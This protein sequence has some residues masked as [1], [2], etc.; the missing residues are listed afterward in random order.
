MKDILSFH[1]AA[2]APVA[3]TPVA[4]ITA[5]GNDLEGSDKK[6]LAFSAGRKAS[7]LERLLS[8]FLRPTL[9]IFGKSVSAYNAFG[10]LG[11]VVAATIAFG[12]TYAKG[13]SLYVTAGLLGLALLV[14]IAN[15]VLTTLITGRDSLV[16]LRYFLT[17][18]AAA[19][20]LLRIIE[21]PILPY[22][23]NLM[24][25]IGAMQGV[26]RIGCFRVGC[27]YGKPAPFGIRYTDRYAKAGFPD[28]LIGVRLFP[29][30]LLESSWIFLSVSTGII[31]SL[32]STVT[33][34]GLSSYILIFSSGRFC[35]EL[36]RGDKA[37]PYLGWLSEAQWISVGMVCSVLILEQMQVLPFH[38]WHVVAGAVM[39]FMAAYVVYNSLHSSVFQLK[40]PAHIASISKALALLEKGR[41]QQTAGAHAV[42]LR[43]TTAGIQISD[44][45]ME[46]QNQ[47][48]HHYTLSHKGDTLALNEAIALAKIIQ[49][50]HPQEEKTKLI[51]DNR[52]TFHFLRYQ[53]I[54]S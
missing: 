23:E 18:M 34:Y 3:H 48:I 53:T 9:R 36:F 39:L 29:I 24:L 41:Q 45:I 2:H 22:L 10:V 37:R 40:K 47:R 30:Q 1:A 21:Q 44:G 35:F 51:D 4:N 8:R 14:S 12:L 15:I 28:P 11:M 20:L 19:A 50:W 32:T 52:N 43:Q 7:V 6:V 17:I 26:G 33:G 54:E 49:S 27:C 25:G 13:L 38:L 31:L 42:H 46:I 16:F 5:Q